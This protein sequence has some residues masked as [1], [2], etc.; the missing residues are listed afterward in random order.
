[1]S[2]PSFG[3]RN[4]VVANLTMFAI[5]AAG[6]IFGLTLRRE[7]FPEVA[8]RQLI[9]VAPYPGAA[10]DEIE[11]ALAIKIEDRLADLKGVKEINT[12]VNESL[13]TVR[14]EFRE[15]VDIDEMVAEAKREID[16]L[17]D[18]PDQADRITISKI[19]PLL[20]VI[21]VTIFGDG[22]E[23]SLKAAI[24][25]VEDDLKSIP[26]M[27][28]IAIGGVRRDEIA[29]EVRPEAMLEYGLSLTD[30][31]D[32]IRSAM[33]EL[34]GGSVRSTTQT[35]GVRAVG[36]EERAAAIREIVVQASAGGSVVRLADIA[37]VRDAFVDQDR[38]FRFN[39]KPTVSATVFKKGD[40]DIVKMSE[41]V[42]AYVAGR[43]GEPLKMTLSD[44]LMAGAG[45]QAGAASARV[46]AYQLG[47]QRG[48]PPGEIATTTDLARFVVGR[49]DLLT[50]N[51]LWGGMLVFITLVL[52]LNWRV[53]FWVAVGLVISLL[54]T[55]VVMRAAG[56]TL[57]LLTMFGLII[58]IGILVD[59]AIVVAEN[60]TAKH[61]QGLSSSQS[62]IE[63]TTQVAW[64]VVATVLTTV[65]A[66]LPLALIGGSIGD[67]MRVLPIVVACS[68]FVSLIESLFILPAHMS[69]SL[70]AR[71]TKHSG[72]RKALGSIEKR[73]DTAR[74]ALF[75]R[76]ITPL[77]TRSLR[78]AL[79]HRY[80]SLIAVVS[81]AVVSVGLVAGGKLEFIFFETDDSETLNI[82]LRMPVGTPVSE[83]DKY[84][85]LIEAA[86]VKQPEVLTV[87]SQS[88]EIGD[89]DG[90]GGGASSG[91]VGQLILELRPVEERL[92]LDQ[93]KSED[94]MLSIRSEV[95]ALPGIKSLRMRGVSGGPGGANLTFTV[96][97]R[98]REQIMVAVD[99]M[100]HRLAEF[101][102]VFDI[103]NDTDSGQRE[104]RFTLRDGATELGFT[105]AT[106]GRQI[107]GAVFGIDAYTFAGFR[108]DVDVRVMLPRAIRQSEEAI[109]NL[110]VFTPAGVPVQIKDV[111]HIEERESF[112]T[113][114]RLDRRRAVTVT[115]DVDRGVGANPESIAANLQPFLRQLERE[116]PGV[117]ILERGRQKD[118][119]ESMSTLP[120][121]MLVA[122]GLIYLVLA[123]LFASY[124][125]PLVVMSAIPFATIG[126]IWGHFVLGYDL[127]FLSLIG[128][129][130]LTGV[131]VN[132]SLIFMEF[133]NGER[134]RGLGV[135]E[136]SIAAGRARIRAILLTTI[137]TVLGLMPLILEKSF[138]ARFLVPMAIT[139]SGGLISATVIILMLLP[140]LLLIV[141]DCK[142]LLRALW[143]GTWTPS[144]DPMG[145]LV[146]SVPTRHNATGTGDFSAKA[147]SNA[148]VA[149]GTESR[150]AL[151]SGEVRDTE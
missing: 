144:P 24:R 33:I 37:D 39:G 149:K 20:P 120:L 77:Y 113:L 56:I 82:E 29:V 1:M 12:T 34:P 90:S 145:V 92:R 130:A 119:A 132:D 27:G 55:L 53:S 109:E 18:L 124:V 117:R 121:G 14:I 114:R 57:N 2:L 147:D 22:D 135:V 71:D 100:Q 54:G 81:I 98:D 86:V 49:L 87:F 122:C 140:C 125:Q 46:Q 62:A 131:V 76:F 72:L 36:V 38:R 80:L 47:V 139:I 148:P 16:A 48:P 41:I 126:M 65:A 101:A 115:A 5:I 60:I 13:A 52:L 83:T 30:V 68:L 3:V 151:D 112:S 9:V 136:A 134:R 8:A 95:G 28:D 75:S 106:L 15:G 107:Q 44:R 116:H 150:E 6:L 19:E 118:F 31:A 23:M 32:R 89:I 84:I 67:F 40:Q 50:R 146:G 127:T 21:I 111:A 105:R 42:K 45:G 93:R 141:D 7:F 79:R 61:E 104:L 94:V 66:F 51:A 110:H 138:Q 63:G 10:P 108:E 78:V 128:F 133:F 11:R 103:S 26:G 102:G 97:G 142:R 43:R 129:V 74:D 25:Q 70:R 88:G 35:L 137:T 96:T 69:H 59:D 99:R 73:C 85:R 17:Q 143:T 4:P 123:W 91:H 58:V 64:P